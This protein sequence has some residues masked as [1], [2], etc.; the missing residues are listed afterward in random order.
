GQSA[1][2]SSEHSPRRWPGRWRPLSR[3]AIFTAALSCGTVLAAAGYY[4][5][6]SDGFTPISMRLLGEDERARYQMAQNAVASHRELAVAGECRLIDAAISREYLSAIESCYQRHG[7]ATVILG[8]SHAED[9]YHALGLTT[10]QPF[11]VGLAQVGC[12][13]YTPNTECPY[14]DFADFLRHNPDRVDRVIYKQSGSFLVADAR[15]NPVNMDLYRQRDLPVQT[16]HD[17]N[18]HQVLSYLKEIAAYTEVVW[19]GPRLEP[20][21]DIWNIVRS[22]CEWESGSLKPAMVETFLK[23]D[24]HLQA[25]VS[26]PGAAVDGGSLAARLSYVSEIDLVNFDVKEDFWDCEAVYW[27]DG[28]HWSVFGEK[29]FGQRI[30]SILADTR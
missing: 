2:E 16:T 9:I 7:P 17:D 26:S 10:Q 29:R 27:R 6:S 15:G 30:A 12:Q 3:P 19:L 24:R 25:L 14:Q 28:D 8:D 4:G 21:I 23:L 5:G 18:V 11:L 20:Q 13:P 22:D 1:G